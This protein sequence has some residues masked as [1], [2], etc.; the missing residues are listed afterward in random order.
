MTVFARTWEAHRTN[1][2]IAIVGAGILGLAAAKTLSERGYTVDVYERWPDV[3]GQASAFEV[4]PGVW[5]DRYYH[6]LFESDADMIALHDELL[7]GQLEWFRSKIAMFDGGR[8]WP[9]VSPFDLMRY[10]PIPAFDRL[11]LGLSVLEMTRR[12]SREEW[13]RISALDWLTSHCG[14]RSVDKVWRPLFLGKFGQDA[15]EV[16]LAWLASK[17]A[18]RR[19]KLQGRAAAAEVLG[20]PRNSFRAIAAAMADR[21]RGAGNTIHLDREVV[22]IER[23][24]EGFVLRCA[25]PGA[26][27]GGTSTPDP[28]RD[29][30]ADIVLLTVSTEAALGITRWPPDYA[31]RLAA[32]RYRTAVVLLLELATPFGDAYWTNIVDPA[33][34]F[35]AV[36]EHTNLVPAERYPARY[37]YVSSYVAPDAEIVSLSTDA[38]LRHC[39]PG[40]RRMRPD[41]DERLV[42]R[43]WSFRERAA[44]PIPVLGNGARL[45]PFETPVDSLFLANT[46]QIYPEDRGTNYSARLGADVG[47]RIADLSA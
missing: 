24:S 42:L 35:L 28:S 4:A 47:G 11:R 21:I 30:R 2:R 43:A 39:L 20:Y 37:V 25:P 31:R 18:L 27:R 34:P 22:S 29:A 6:H 8:S 40:L 26:Y 15:R 23:D 44:Q 14:Q 32:W 3:A 19:R 1:S 45:L 5:L 46:T 38:L 13:D 7:P 36:V 10:G 12:S 16:P 17:L 33:M 9:F 41:F